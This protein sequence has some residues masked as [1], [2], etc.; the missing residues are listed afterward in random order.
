MPKGTLRSNRGWREE[1]KIKEG[2]MLNRRDFLKGLAVAAAYGAYSG[3]L[4]A[5]VKETEPGKQEWKCGPKT[6]KSED[7]IDKS[8]FENFV[9]GPAN[10]F[11]YSAA[12]SVAKS[13]GMIF[14][15]LLII[16][17]EGVG[18]S[19]L[20]KAVGNRILHD[21]NSKKV[22]YT[23]ADVFTDEFIGAVKS[24]CYPDFKSKYSGIDVVLIDDIEYMEGKEDV[25]EKLVAAFQS[26]L[27]SKKQVVLAAKMPR[28]FS[29]LE[30]LIS[31]F[32]HG[33]IAEIQPPGF[34]QRVAF[35]KH[36][37]DQNSFNLPNRV[38]DFM[39]IEFK[40]LRELEGAFRN[41]AAFSSFTGE[42][43]TVRMVKKVLKV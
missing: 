13:P 9:V 28:Q 15:P 19:H 14:N 8:T 12:M 6:V 18:K 1:F 38:T 4:F 3:P 30:R 11:A 24:N 32:E 43:I 27:G 39:A 29:R 36:L 5:D 34:Q 21:N 17:Y 16:G 2:F 26:P 22:I 35:L 42:D 40:G 31:R 7:S 37:A 41:V 23:T 20:L 25:Q 33:L 10:E